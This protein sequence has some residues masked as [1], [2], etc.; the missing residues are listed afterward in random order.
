MVWICAGTFF[1]LLAKNPKE[2]RVDWQCDSEIFNIINISLLE[3]FCISNINNSKFSICQALIGY[4]G[5]KPKKSRSA[6]LCKPPPAC[7]NKAAVRWL[8]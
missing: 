6:A 3:S 1:V 8:N 7:D 5:L 2:N 4:K